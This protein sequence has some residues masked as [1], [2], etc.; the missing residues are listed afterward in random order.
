MATISYSDYEHTYRFCESLLNLDIPNESRIAIVKIFLTVNEKL[1]YE[2]FEY[3]SK[4]ID[5]MCHALDITECLIKDMV[6]DIMHRQHKEFARK[7]LP[8]LRKDDIDELAK[9]LQTIA[10]LN[11]EESL[12]QKVTAELLT[13][14]KRH[15]K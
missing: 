15:V 9:H 8:D 6:A 11:L 5:E 7:E 10:E 12:R 14:Y 4:Y 1:G 13:V 3:C 2:P